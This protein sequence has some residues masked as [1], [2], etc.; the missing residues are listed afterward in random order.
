MPSLPLQRGARSV[1][2]RFI[3]KETK[4]I[5]RSAQPIFPRSDDMPTVVRPLQYAP[6]S[7]IAVQAR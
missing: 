6:L 1:G 3:R 4:A 2:T 5:T 7:L